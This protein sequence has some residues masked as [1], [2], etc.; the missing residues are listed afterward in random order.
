MP[1]VVPPELE[2]LMIG[3]VKLKDL[4]EGNNT[5]RNRRII[6][7]HLAGENTNAISRTLGKEGI[8]RSKENDVRSFLKYRD[9]VPNKA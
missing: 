6:E 8:E 5:L 1:V 4:T 7:L 3:K 2:K 9:I